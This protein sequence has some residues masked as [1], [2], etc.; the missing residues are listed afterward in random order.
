MPKT[1]FDRKNIL[2]VGGAGFVGSHLCDEL[3]K[4]NKV[5]CVD[6]FS[7]GDEKNIDHL[8]ADPNFKFIRHDMSEPLDLESL[9]E[10]EVFKVKFQGIQEIYN[11]AC[12][13]S[14]KQFDEQRIANLLANSF[15]VKH[16]LDLAVK[17]EAK[18]LHY[19]S[20]VVYGQ[21]LPGQSRLMEDF[22]GIVDFTSDRSSYDEGKRFAETMVRNYRKVYNLEAKIMRLFRTYGPR[23]KLNDNQMIPD[24]VSNALDDK[25]LVIYGDESFSSSFVYISDVIDSSIKMMANEQVEVL[26]IGSDIDV[27]FKTI[28]EK[29]IKHVGS[30]SNIVFEKEAFFVSNLPLPNISASLD[31][32]GW[33]PIITLDKGLEK[34]V[35][36]LR[37]SKGLKSLASK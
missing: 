2:I 15:V 23:M 14:P 12:P 19:S 13:T 3:I 35:D 20:S 17:Y 36:D 8:L 16:V 11:L 10:L 25:D 29:I 6:N 7:T 37:A 22:M 31:K 18:L 33:L 24:F 1:I 4:K 34:T 32:V 5:I 28:A 27:P 21:R 26:N 9:K 30:A